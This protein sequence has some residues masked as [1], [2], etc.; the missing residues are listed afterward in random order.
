MDYLE[1]FKALIPA[2]ADLGDAYLIVLLDNSDNLLSNNFDETVRS[3][4]IVYLTAHTIYLSRQLKGR[5]AINSL[6][7]GQLSASF[8]NNSSSNDTFDQSSYGQ[9]YKNIL[10]SNTITPITKFND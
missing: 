7:E 4:L 1:L 2:Y 6:T 3:N 10:N 9:M 5:N 8:S